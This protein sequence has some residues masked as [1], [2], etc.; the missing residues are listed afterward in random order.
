MKVSSAVIFVVSLFL[1]PPV[2]AESAEDAWT[3]VGIR[4]SVS[5][6]S[7]STNG[8][9]ASSSV[10]SVVRSSGGETV[11]EVDVSAESD[12]ERVEHH[13]LYEGGNIDVDIRE[14]S[15]DGNA[16]VGVSVDVGDLEDDLG[17]SEDFMEDI[18]PEEFD[19]MMSE[20]LFEEEEVGTRGLSKW[21]SEVKEWFREYFQ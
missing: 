12:G 6:T 1:A 3:N 16:S 21:W 18:V 8:G 20:E 5:A 11:V 17:F 4:S 10:S 2:W 13:D 7:E 9:S 15:G 19:E 14:E